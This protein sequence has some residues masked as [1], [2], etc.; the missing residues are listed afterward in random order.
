LPKSHCEIQVHTILVC[1]LYAIKC[2]TINYIELIKKHED[3][4]QNSIPNDLTEL[5]LASLGI[6]T[7]ALTLHD[8]RSVATNRTNNLNN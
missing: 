2:G 3:Y 4:A 6:V 1:T 5:G 7:Q 8:Y